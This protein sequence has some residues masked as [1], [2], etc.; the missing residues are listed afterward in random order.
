MNHYWTISTVHWHRLRNPTFVTRR[1]TLSW[2]P[3]IP[4]PR[5]SISASQHLQLSSFREL[6]YQSEATSQL[7]FLVL[8]VLDCLFPRPP[9]YKSY[10]FIVF[11][12]LVLLLLHYFNSKGLLFSC[13]RLPHSANVAGSRSWSWLKPTEGEDKNSELNGPKQYLLRVPST[14]NAEKVFRCKPSTPQILNLHNIWPV[15]FP[16]L[17]QLFLRV[18]DPAKKCLSRC[19]QIRAA[20]YRKDTSD[21]NLYERLQLSY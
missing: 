12:C 15:G 11:Y 3:N 18:K 5:S 19:A 16:D 8:I 6:N 4:V 1:L 17:W 20:M 13:L 14:G 7:L 9:I 10:L 2:R 21:I